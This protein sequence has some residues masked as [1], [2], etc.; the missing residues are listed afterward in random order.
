M[1]EKILIIN[2]GSSSLK[3]SL[4]GMPENKEIVNG[5]VEKI[6]NQDSF[7]TL[8]FNDQKLEKSRVI[9]N[10]TEAVIIMLEELLA[11]KFINDVSEIKGIGH[12]V[13]HG[14]EIYNNSVIITEE[15]IDNIKEL[16][17]FAK[18]HHPGNLDGIEALKKVFPEVP[19]VAV[20]D[21]AFHQTM[22]EENYMYAVPYSWY[23]ENGVRKYGFHGTSHKYIT[24]TL[25]NYFGKKDV[26]LIVCHIG[27]GA[28][29]TCIK[30]GLSQNTSM[31]LTPL[32][33]LVM[34]TRCGTIDS[35]IIEYI[36][37]ERNLSVEE[38]T[39]LLNKKSGLLGIAGENDFR[40]LL[41]LA[42]NGDKKA[43][44]AIKMLKKSIINFIAQYYVEL[45]GEVDAL[46]FTAGIG[47][48]NSELRA[49]IINALS[50]AMNIYLNEESNNKISRYKEKQ[51]GIIST[52]DSKFKVMVIP[53]NEEYIIL[54]DTCELIKSQ[55]KGYKKVLKRL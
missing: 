26:N 9:T 39:S 53:T 13:V 41:S 31:G 12:R 34:G 6:G 33:G 55:T 22:P 25:Q 27:S 5:Y 20:F 10:H 23:E 3:F 35:S 54:K 37:N 42:D 44:L 30:D 38:V 45:N 21:T 15:V 47:E 48:N 24:E 49:D 1:E 28:S 7:Y 8:K 18:L 50:N 2:A 29:I 19:M 11:N 16:T 46:I 43:I 51:E 32:D 52:E 40:D 14:G 4:Y 36:C 17:K